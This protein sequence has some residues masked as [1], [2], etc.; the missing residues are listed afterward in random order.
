MLK[1]RTAVANGTLAEDHAAA[2]Q[3]AGRPFSARRRKIPR[4]WTVSPPAPSAKALARAAS[5]IR[6]FGSIVAQT[7]PASRNPP[8]KRAGHRM[9]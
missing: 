9:R 3:W 5:S 1:V 2:E 7:E 8:G 4:S 6:P